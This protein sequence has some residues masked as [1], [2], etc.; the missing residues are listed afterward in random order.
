VPPPP[1][2]VAALER[3][4]NGAGKHPPSWKSSRSSPRRATVKAV[5]KRPVLVDGP[6]IGF[7]HQALWRSDGEATEASVILMR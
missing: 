7:L 2:R 3:E 5:L 1:R 6:H 4:L